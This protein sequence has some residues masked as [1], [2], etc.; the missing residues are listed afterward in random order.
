M[1]AQVQTVSLAKKLGSK[2]VNA[3]KQFKDAPAEVGNSKLPPGIEDG[4]ARLV[5]CRIGEFKEGDNRGQP[6]F[7]A[8]GIML[9]PVMHEGF[10]IEGK[11]TS[12]GPIPLC[13]TPKSPGKKKTFADHY[14]VFLNHLKNLGVDTQKSE[15]MTPE[16]VDAFLTGSMAALE[17]A[18]P[19]FAVRTW[20]G[21][22]SKDFPNPRTNEEWNGLVEY[23]A[24]PNASANGVTTHDEMMGGE[25]FTEPEQGGDVGAETGDSTSLAGADVTDG[26]VIAAL[27]EIAD[28]DPNGATEDGKIA[29]KQLFDAAAA[30]GWTKEQMEAPDL[31]WADI[32][33]SI[34]QG[35]PPPATTPPATK[36]APTVGAKFKFRKRDSKGSPLVNA[37]T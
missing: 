19:T 26:D 6:F 20:K 15:A 10:K 31:S 33:A 29:M 22:A 27:V 37:R 1:P 9:A 32:G 7:M 24:D 3:H 11:R 4:V 12:I 25:P 30:I 35:T 14:A 18:R 8:T 23:V 28:G 36:P 5:S 21:K 13:D 16:Q 2:L 17:K 34:L